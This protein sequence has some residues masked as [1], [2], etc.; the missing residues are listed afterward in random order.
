MDCEPK[1]RRSP[2]HSGTTSLHARSLG[3]LALALLFAGCAT[4]P[5][6]SPPAP[7]AAPPPPAPPPTVISI[8]AVGDIMLGTDFPKNIL[9]DDDGIGFL[10]HVTPILAG[11]DVAFG[12]LEGVLM[13]GG[14]PVKQCGSSTSCFVFRTPTRYAAYLRDAGFDLVSLANNHARD[15]GEEGRD[16]SMAALDAVGIRH[17]GREGT[18]AGMTVK[19]VR[20][21]MVA[22]APNVGAN[23]LNDHELAVEF[24]RSLA[25]A[26]DI[27]I[28][29]FHAG[30]EGAG[31]E[32]LPYAREFYAGEDRGDVV[33]FARAMIDAGADLLL[34]HGPHVPRAMELYRD[35]LIA[36]SLGNFATY[37]GIGV[38]GNRGIAPIVT[39][40]LDAEGR[41]VGGHID[42]TIQL[43]PD[44]PSIDPQ[45]R[46]LQLIRELTAAALPYGWL[47]FGAD[48]R[49]IRV[50]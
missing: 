30:G 37:Y 15:F 9:P 42:S 18:W 6:P 28:V 35:R 48:G 27:V 47:E 3:A 13:D 49:I 4:V 22:F 32:A 46:A 5:P 41:F 11:A 34:G 43:R 23:S 1:P 26:N 2:S 24:V 20:V 8:A 10:R 33:M 39:A 45:Q 25:A 31:A 14:E 19:G 16:S 40:R 44:G 12:N 7:E 21:A 36:Y 17:S 38:E 29:S 50:P